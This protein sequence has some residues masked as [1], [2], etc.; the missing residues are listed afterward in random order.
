MLFGSD[1]S[2]LVVKRNAC[3]GVM[4]RVIQVPDFEPIKFSAD[5]DLPANPR[6]LL[7]HRSLSMVN[8]FTRYSPIPLRR[9]LGFPSA[10]SRTMRRSP[11][12]IFPAIRV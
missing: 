12:S 4:K 10:V 1:H 8:P 6:L 7:R 3:L 11:V 2:S 9:R 5:D